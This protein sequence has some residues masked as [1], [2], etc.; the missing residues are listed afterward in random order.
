MINIGTELILRHKG[1]EYSCMVTNFKIDTTPQ[2]IMIGWVEITDDK[3]SKWEPL[4]LMLDLIRSMRL[5]KPEQRELAEV[6][7]QSEAHV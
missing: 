7:W 5:F 1:K 4:H 6:Y 2:G 3:Q